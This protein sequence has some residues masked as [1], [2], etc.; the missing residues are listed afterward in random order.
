MILIESNNDKFVAID[1][2]D[3]GRII[4]M[5]IVNGDI[6]NLQDFSQKVKNYF[7]EIEGFCIAQKCEVIMCGGDSILVVIS[8]KKLEL[9]LQKIS[10]MK[11]PFTVSIGIGS[12]LRMSYFAL[13]EAKARGRN[14]IVS[15]ENG[16]S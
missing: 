9:I 7:A 4:E 5:E 11:Y 16:I 2:D 13:K 8:Q 6:Q 14:Q 15:L 1:A 10:T 12:S 3:I